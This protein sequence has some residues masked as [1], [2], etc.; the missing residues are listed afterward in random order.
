MSIDYK[1]GDVVRLINS[2]CTKI[3]SLVGTDRRLIIAC[4]GG[5]DSM[6]LLHCAEFLEG[7]DI[8]VCHVTYP[9]RPI[10][11]SLQALGAVEEVCKEMG[12]KL[13]HK[14]IPVLDS[15]D[16][17][18]IENLCRQIRYEFFE[19]TSTVWDTEFVAT[20]H[21]SND[22]L[23]TLLMR[24]CRGTGVKGLTG[25]AEKKVSSQEDSTCTFIRPMLSLS[26][27]EI[28][29]ICEDRALA[30]VEDSTNKDETYTRNLIRSKVIPVLEK[31]YP[32]C[33]QRSHELCLMFA[34]MD[35][36]LDAEVHRVRSA[37]DAH[38]PDGQT[39]SRGGTLTLAHC[40]LDILRYKSD[41]LLQRLLSSLY[42]DMTNGTDLDKINRHMYRLAINSIKSPRDSYEKNAAVHEWPSNIEIRLFRNHF[43]MRNLNRIPST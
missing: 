31:V 37:I 32:G 3:K 15:S 29:T 20:A 26:K 10:K 21:S 6:A 9:I 17:R 8:A 5:A 34:D 4:S 22:Q 1:P 14:D 43:T 41:V 12:Y 7:F 19:E 40:P 25:I 13:F 30:F 23:E 11:E 35:K 2:V 18:N 33:T 16:S 28:L 27:N 24:I 39:W 36:E 38:A 42:S